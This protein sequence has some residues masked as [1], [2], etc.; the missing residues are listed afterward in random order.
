MVAKEWRD[1]RWKL[2]IGAVLVLAMGALIPVDTLFP[3][4]YSLFGEPN[5]VVAP[6]PEEDA[7]YLRY[8]LWSQWFTE[9]SGNLILTL[10]AAVLGAGLVS[11]ET[12]RSTILLL[13]NKPVSRERVLLTK[14]VVNAGVLLVV[15]LLGSGALLITTGMLGYPQ[16]VGGVL[17]S[18]V[19]MWL[20]LLFVLGTALLLSVVLDSTLLAVVGTFLVWMLTSVAPAFVAQQ[21]AVH[22]LSSQ[23]EFPA[24][25]FDALALSPYWTS[26][27]AYSG[28]NFPTLQLLVSSVA[29]TV[30]LLAALWL[31]RR[32]A[33]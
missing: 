31:F 7:G 27:S 16:H 22:Y 28:N 13:L 25:L 24:T 23:N 11:E 1:A 10:V 21:I 9:A 12:N 6:S 32:K 30:P 8:L 5:N 14:Y 26:L 33:Y 17:I 20:G 15:T 29:A 3:S 19:L 2:L 18:S 4:S